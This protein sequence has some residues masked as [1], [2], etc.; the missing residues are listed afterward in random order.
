MI[1]LRKAFLD[2][3]NLVF[4]MIRFYGLQFKFYFFLENENP[5]AKE[6]TVKMI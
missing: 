5:K 3:I 2:L 6:R 1:A 4:Q